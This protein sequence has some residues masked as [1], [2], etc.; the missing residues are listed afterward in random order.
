VGPRAWRPADH[1]MTFT[2][3]DFPTYTSLVTAVAMDTLY[4]HNYS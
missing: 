2:L 3:L 1:K 4:I